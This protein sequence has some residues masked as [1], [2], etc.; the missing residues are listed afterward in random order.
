MN[1]GYFLA[2]FNYT[3]HPEES[4]H[5]DPKPI[6]KEKL[7]RKSV[8]TVVVSPDE[9]LPFF[10]Q[11][12][13]MLVE[14]ANTTSDT[15][16]FNAQDNRLYMKTQAKDSNGNWRDIEYL[17]SSWC[18]NS[19]HYVT[20]PPDRY[21]T[22][23]APV[24]EGEFA[25]SL[26]IVLSYIDPEDKVDPSMKKGDRAYRGRRELTVYSNEFPSSINPAQFW[27]KPQYY[28]SGIMD[29]YDE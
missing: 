20:L 7:F 15:I 25:T 1:R 5:A 27:R 3:G 23:V 22:F 12:Q 29:P 16:V 18:G 26:R 24:Y 6:E 14:V 17:P 9:N 10:D 11:A 21:W 19:Y 2:N 13:G 8:L 28:P 4:R